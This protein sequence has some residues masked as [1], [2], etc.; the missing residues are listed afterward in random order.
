MSE[1]ETTSKISRRTVLK[2]T[3]VAGATSGFGGTAAGGYQELLDGLDADSVTQSDDVARR[4]NLLAIVSGWIGIGPAEINAR[5]NPA[6]RLVEGEDYE[7][8]WLNGDGNHHNFNILNEEGDVLETT[9]TLT[10]QGETLS[11]TFTADSEMAS[12]KCFP[13]PVQM[14]GPVELIESRDVHELRVTVEDGEGNPLTAYVS[15]GDQLYD[16]FAPTVG[17]S[18]VLARGEAGAKV[19]LSR[20]DTLEDGTYTVTAWAYNHEMVTEEVTINGADEEITVTVPEL[21]PGDPAQEYELSLHEDGWH[22]ESPDEIAG[23]VNPTLS[24]TSGE[25][26]RVNWRNTIGRKE[27]EN[28]VEGAPVRGEPLPGHNFV[29]AQTNLNTILRS[30]FLDEEGQTQSVEFVAGDDLGVYMDQTQT[31]AIGEFS[32]EGDSDVRDVGAGTDT[33]GDGFTDDGTTDDEEC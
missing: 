2:G 9:G 31:T 27:L 15:V 23:Q 28:T 7:V 17:F 19:G 5:T 8:W 20:F 22:G 30:E 3:A 11:V 12:Y 21:S 24:V 26:Y 1:K 29:A 25:T 14:W 10:E 4:F 16:L 18:S 13:H 6:L 33:E 32:V